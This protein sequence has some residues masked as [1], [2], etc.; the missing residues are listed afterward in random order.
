ML[1]QTLAFKLIILSLYLLIDTVSALQKINNRPIIGI[2]T[3]PS[4]FQVRWQ[5]SDWSYFP[6]S[7]VKFLESSGAR[8]VPIP[9]DAS[10]DN[11]TYL[12]NSVNG[13][14]FTGGGASLSIDKPDQNLRSPSNIT[15]AGAYL[16]KLAI[17]ANDKGDY[18]PVW[19][20][21]QGWELF[22]MVLSE[23]LFILE[24]VTWEIN[25][26]RN[27]SF[28]SKFQNSRLWSGLDEK[29]LNWIQYQNVTFYDHNY[30]ISVEGFY[31]ND[32]LRNNVNLLGITYA[33]YGKWFAACG[34]HKKYPFY[35]SQFHSEKMPFEWKA[36]LRIS[37][38]HK[39]IQFS[40]YIS[41]FIVNEAKKNFHAFPNKEAE[42]LSLIY[43]WQITAYVPM[44]S[45]LGPSYF[46]STVQKTPNAWPGLFN[47]TV[48]DSYNN[49]ENNNNIHINLTD[50]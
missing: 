44:T 10:Y 35:G 40:Q 6:S 41:N 4:D 29:M 30:S 19:V 38:D 49:N 26:N 2:L 3:T 8:V 42:R 37:H 24:K 9:Y 15:S 16:L 32:K 34:E 45:L 18:F 36:A 7:Y 22:N 20:T 27:M 1:Q 39:T 11:L 23:N 17:Q 28:T 47:I 12:F 21:C 50:L 46:F 31:H 14:L 43:N 25:M 13:L 48:P 33:G 5:R